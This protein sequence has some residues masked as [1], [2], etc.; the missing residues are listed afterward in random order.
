ML[1]NKGC[2][3]SWNAKNLETW[4]SGSLETKARNA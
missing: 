2:P 3:K 1:H 4:K